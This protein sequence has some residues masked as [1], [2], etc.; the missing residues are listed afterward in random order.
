MEILRKPDQF[1][2][3]FFF[4]FPFDPTWELAPTFGA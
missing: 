1:I 2:I 3:V 4:F